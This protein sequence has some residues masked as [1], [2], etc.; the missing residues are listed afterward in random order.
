MP[1]FSIAIRS[2]PMPKAKPCHSAGS[3]PAAAS[4]FGCTMPEP[5][6]S[7]HDSPSPIFSCPPDQSQRMSTSAEGSV[8]GKCEARKRSS[9]EGT[10]KKARQN[11]SSTHFRLAMLMSR[12]RARPSTW[13]NIG[14]WVWSMSMR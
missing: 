3:T 12:S 8:K 11:S 14:V 6:I 13:W 9:T 5:R 7:S 4:T 1:Y 2:M 10:S